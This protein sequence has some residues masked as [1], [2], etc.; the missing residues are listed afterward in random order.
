MDKQDRLELL[1]K[2]LQ[3]I[4]FD[5]LN[6]GHSECSR[7]FFW[8]SVVSGNINGKDTYKTIDLAVEFPR[9]IEYFCKTHNVKPYKTS[10][11]YRFLPKN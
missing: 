5:I 9:E 3:I 7:D 11:G 2:K 1:K 10:R 4:R 8:I 6:K